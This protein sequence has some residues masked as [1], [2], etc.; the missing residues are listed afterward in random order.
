MAQ[1]DKDSSDGHRGVV[2]LTS[3]WQGGRGK[4]KVVEGQGP[5]GMVAQVYLRFT[6]SSARNDKHKKHLNAV[7]H[8]LHALT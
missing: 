7:Q 8:T 4:D 2:V 3:G 1:E 6:W 5:L